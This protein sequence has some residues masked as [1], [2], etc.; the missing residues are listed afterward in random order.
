MKLTEARK[1]YRNEY[2][3]FT[4][5]DRNQKTGKVIYHSKSRENVHKKIRALPK[6]FDLSL[7]F[8]GPLLPKGWGTL[9]C[10]K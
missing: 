10:M 6:P 8:A 9:L 4:Y 2:I 1:R 5:K 3:L 7:I